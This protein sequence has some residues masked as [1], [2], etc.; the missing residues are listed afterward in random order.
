MLR[1]FSMTIVNKQYICLISFAI[2]L[3]LSAMILLVAHRDKKRALLAEMQAENAKSAAA[4]P[5]M[6]PVLQ[7]ASSERNL[8]PVSI[9]GYL[10]KK[11]RQTPALLILV[12]L[13]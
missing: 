7:E 8:R 10:Y 2:L 11:R 5:D 3:M 6:E 4:L 12:L 1:V 9:R 13:F